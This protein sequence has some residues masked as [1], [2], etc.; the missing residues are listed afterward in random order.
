MDLLVK[1]GQDLDSVGRY[2]IGELLERVGT[3]EAALDSEIIVAWNTVVTA[4]VDVGSRQVNGQDRV[5]RKSELEQMVLKCVGKV[6]V[7]FSG[8][9]VEESDDKRVQTTSSSA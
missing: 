8:R 9:F 5:V 3:W 2:E 1:T 6:G 4:S 7:E